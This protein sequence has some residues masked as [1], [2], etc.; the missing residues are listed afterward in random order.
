MT[1]AAAACELTVSEEPHWVADG[2]S[3]LF[4]VRD[5]AS[6]AWR[7]EDMQH[8]EFTREIQFVW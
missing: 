7:Y 6:N 2:L 8:A 1:S 4:A 5:E 3:F